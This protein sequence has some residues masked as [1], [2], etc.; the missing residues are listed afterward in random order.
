MKK[1]FRMNDRIYQVVKYISVAFLLVQVV[2]ISYTVFGRFVLNKTPRWSEEL[3]LMCMVW[4]SV[5]SASLAERNKAHI[6]VQLS[7]LILPVSVMRVIDKINVIVKIV[8][9]L[10]LIVYGIKFS[11]MTKGAILPGL[12]IS[13][14]WLHASIPAAG[15]FLLLTVLF[16]LKESDDV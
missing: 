4:F 12:D 8:F 15:G 5:L 9:S 2:I 7:R 13:R 11:I 6:R 10:F 1:E 14:S 16:N 3:A